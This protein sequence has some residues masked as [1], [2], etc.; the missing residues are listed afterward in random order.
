MSEKKQGG[1]F[2]FLFL[3][4]AILMIFIFESIFGLV[5]AILSL[6]FSI[7]DL[8]HKNPVVYISLVGSIL[9][10]LFY[11]VSFIVSTMVVSDV[12]S[13][14]KLN[15]YRYYEENLER[16]EE[17]YV[18]S[19]NKAYGNNDFVLA[20][21]EIINNTNLQKLDSCD[22]YVIVNQNNEKYEAYVKCDNYK[23]DGYNSTH[24]G[25]NLNE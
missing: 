2:A 8:K 20:A 24:I 15:S 10:I 23:T 9:A 14:A 1:G 25:G 12:I 4:I 21:D 18:I 22:G 11:I 17:K 16:Y 19:Q 3:V 7:K 6:I 5:F 13:D